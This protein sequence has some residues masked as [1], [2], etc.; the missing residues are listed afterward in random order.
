MNGQVIVYVVLAVVVGWLACG[1]FNEPQPLGE[2]VDSAVSDLQNGEGGKALESLGN[3]T[4]GEQ[5]RDDVRD[6]VAP[7]K[8]Q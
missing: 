2:R 1:Y 4:R 5:L 8:R 3:S 7:E 6:A